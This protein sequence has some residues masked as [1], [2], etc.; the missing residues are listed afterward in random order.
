MYVFVRE[1]TSVGHGTS[2]IIL[3]RGDVWPDDDPLVVAHPELFTVD[4]PVLRRSGGVVEVATAAPGER[5]GNR[6][7]QN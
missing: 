1:S 4:P 7:A 6:R 2:T 5:R 3:A